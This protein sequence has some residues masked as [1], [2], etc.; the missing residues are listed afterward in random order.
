M[1]SPLNRDRHITPQ[2]PVHRRERVIV[3]ET[4]RD[5]AL[6]GRQKRK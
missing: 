3:V 1:I 6:P 2:S 5:D 4:I